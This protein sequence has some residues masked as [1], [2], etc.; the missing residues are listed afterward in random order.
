VDAQRDQLISE[1]DKAGLLARDYKTEGVGPTQ[2]GHNAGGD[3][4][5]TDGMMRIGVLATKSP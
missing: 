5:F 1:L 4:Y 3:R 2:D